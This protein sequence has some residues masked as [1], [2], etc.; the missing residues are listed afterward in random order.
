MAEIIDMFAWKPV[1]YTVHM[2]HHP[3]GRL[4]VSVSDVADDPRSLASVAWAL[5]EAVEMIKEKVNS[6]EGA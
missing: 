2:T 1:H 3:D 6:L 5:G 4:E